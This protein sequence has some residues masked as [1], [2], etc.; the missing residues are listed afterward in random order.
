MKNRWAVRYGSLSSWQLWVVFWILLLRLLFAITT[1]PNRTQ[2]FS[3]LWFFAWL[4]SSLAAIAFVLLVMKLGL[5]KRLQRKPSPWLNII[6]MACAGVIANSTTAALAIGWGLDHE[7]LW[8]VRIPG[9]IVLHL[10]FFFLVN[11]IRASTT[12]RNEHIRELVNTEHRLRG[13]RESAKQIANDELE[14]LREKSKS[15]ILPHIDTIEQL[16]SERFDREMR[17]DLL[18]ELQELIDTEVRPLS[19]EILDEAEVLTSIKERETPSSL[20][21]PRWRT[22]FVVADSIYPA[23]QLAIMTA[24]LPMLQFT[25]IDHRSA[26]RGLLS[27]VAIGLVLLIAKSLLPR[28]KETRIG[29]GLLAVTAISALS[30]MPAWWITWQE[31]GFTPEVIYCGLTTTG[32]N[33]LMTFLIAYIHAT[34]NA[35]ERY[36]KQLEA[37]NLEL[38]KEVA[39]FE[40]KLALNRRE[41]SRI[42]HGDVQAS[43]SAALTRLKRTEE[44]EPYVFELIK[45]NIEHAKQALLTPSQAEVSFDEAMNSLVA[46]W[47]NVCAIQLEVTARAK[48]ALEL[49]SDARACVNEICKEA[50]SNAVRHGDAKRATITIDRQQDDL[51]DLRVSNDGSPVNQ[52]H[53]SGLGSAMIDELTLDWSIKSQN[54]Q[55][56][57]VAVIPL[58]TR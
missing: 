57:L 44:P 34:D 4:F 21:R 41:W 54:G 32:T 23:V 7:W 27:G 28:T 46:A 52:N 58:Q 43:L 6:T 45:N 10:A 13:Y 2:N 18:D 25:L 30:T 37:V 1:D 26:V 38:S 19:K 49:S 5:Y 15:V 48:R 31:Y 29:R 53:T 12:E 8:Q 9:A 42:I 33:I 50:I 39:L 17:N 35:R 36:A 20:G 16:V 56:T 51:L 14:R 47:A 11:G 24:S 22:T 55:T 3:P 40:Q